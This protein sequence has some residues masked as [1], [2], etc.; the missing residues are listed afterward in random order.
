MAVE[1]FVADTGHADAFAGIAESFR[2]A[3]EQDVVIGVVGDTGLIGCLKRRAQVLAEIHG[4]I[5]KVFHDDDVILVC[6]ISYRA[7]FFIGHA[8]PCRVVGVAI[9]DSA[10]VSAFQI[11]LQLAA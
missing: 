2:T 7:Q 9:D 1:E 10:D 3:D 6:Q 5:S 8:D 4:E 11:A